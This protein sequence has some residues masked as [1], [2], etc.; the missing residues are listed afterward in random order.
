MTR[1]STV[2]KDELLLG[3]DIGTASVKGVLT[4][5]DGT[6]VATA[7]VP[8]EL[9]VPRPGWAEHDA[10]RTWW[11]GPVRVVRELLSDVPGDRVRGVAIS[12]IGPAMCPTDA[13]GEPLRPAIL[14]GIDVRAAREGAHLEQVLGR[15]T[16]LARTGSV[17]TSQALGP[18]LLWFR[19]HEPELFARTAFLLPASAF[20]LR[21]LTGEYAIDQHTACYFNP[22]FDI[23]AGT[24]VDDPTWRDAVL[25]EQAVELPRV[26][27]TLETAGEVTPAAAGVTGVPAG[28]PVTVGTIDSLAEALSVGVRAPGD[29]MIQ[30]GSTLYLILV[31]RVLEVDERFWSTSFAAP[32]SI[33]VEAGMAAAGLLTEWFRSILGEPAPSFDELVA[34]AVLTDP[35]ADGLVA[36]P[37]FSGERAPIHDPDA[38]GLLFGLTLRHRRGHVYRALLESTA[39]GTRHIL[40]GLAEIGGHATRAVAV[41]G[42]ATTTSW[43]QIVSDVTGLEQ[44]LPDVTVG[45]SYGDAWIAGVASGLVDARDDWTRIRHHIVPAPDNG[46]YAER[47]EVYREL[48]RSTR[49]L[50]HRVAH[51]QRERA[52]VGEGGFPE[53]P[54]A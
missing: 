43:P 29:L 21:R 46:V 22:L 39:L 31:S 33:G 17:L 2:A 45:A 14:Y 37:Y 54:V 15:E 20:L 51:A 41:G 9:S 10:E 23:N 6:V 32:G 16:I 44:E 53:G 13:H 35:G 11:A 8:H 52:P 1:P 36:L 47:Y 28:T 5:P 49:D 40:D 12:G 25:G 30:Y 19:T 50:M 3:V 48:Y 26:Q 38:L 27:W 34:E 18:K 4:T 24:W 42:G 7:R